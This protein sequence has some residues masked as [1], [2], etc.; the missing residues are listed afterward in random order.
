VHT[1]DREFLAKVEVF[2]RRLNLSADGL[3]ETRQRLRIKML[4]GPQP[5]IATYNGSVPLAAWFRVCAVHEATDVL[6]LRRR[7]RPLL[8]EEQLGRIADRLGERDDADLQ[9]LRKRHVARF[10][11][12]LEESIASLTDREKTLLRFSFIDGLSIDALA[13]L[14]QVHRATAARWLVQIR[15]RLFDGIQ[16]QFAL[17]LRTS[18]SEFR[19]LFGAIRS[20]LRISLSR[21]LGT[22]DR[23]AATAVPR[24]AR[25]LPPEDLTPS[26]GSVTTIR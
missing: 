16:A 23:R 3:D 11:Q 18:S 19:S 25:E 10:Q 15:A 24:E 7:E 21:F 14:Y 1:F 5:R 17:E 9:L 12:A 22:G 4:T 2:A 20:H 6:Q 8:D 26:H 13:S